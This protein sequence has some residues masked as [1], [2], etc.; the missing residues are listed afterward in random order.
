[1]TRTMW[2]ASVRHLWHRPSQLLLAL[3]GLA[4]GVA[5]ITAVD[6][7]TASSQRAFDLSVSAVSGPASEEITGGPAGL[8][9]KRYVE[10]AA[11]YPQL[12]LAPIVDGYVVVGEE[13]L[14]LVGIDPLAS[15]GVRGPTDAALAPAAAPLSELARWLTEPGAVVMASD[16][17]TRLGI[18][19]NVPFE[20]EVAGK[21]ARAVSIADHRLWH[22][23][24]DPVARGHRPG[25][26]M[27]GSHRPTHAHRGR[28][29]CQRRARRRTRAAAR[30]ASAGSEAHGCQ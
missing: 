15:A 25:A 22:R 8:D 19:L 4:L 12:S 16:T 30:I 18:A 2:A 28:D 6:L 3:V 13:A 24:R 29:T 23:E 10:L 14:D 27:A 11:A 9:E 17:A 21:S 1:M 7:A 26:G 20:L 5:T